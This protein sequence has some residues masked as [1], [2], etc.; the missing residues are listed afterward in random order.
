MNPAAGVSRG[1]LVREGSMKKVCL[2]ATVLFLFV[3]CSFAVT[4][5]EYGYAGSW[6]P[7]SFLVGAGNDR[8]SSG[9]SFDYDDQL[10][11]SEYF[12]LQAPAWRIDVDMLGITNRGWQEGWST[13]DPLA[14]GSGTR[15]SG[16]YD[17]T[18]VRVRL[19]IDVV[20]SQWFFLRMEPTVGVS[21]IGRQNYAF[22]Q[23]SLHRALGMQTVDLEYE[24]NSNKAYALFGGVVSLGGI[25]SLSWRTNLVV[26]LR[27]A[28]SNEIGFS[29][30]QKADAFVALRDAAYNDLLYVSF[31]YTWTQTKS[32]WTTA[33]LYDDYLRGFSLA[34]NVNAGFIRL[35][36]SCCLDTRRGYGTIGVDVL[37]FFSPTYWRRSDFYVSLGKTSMM[38]V[39]FFDCCLEKPFENSKFSLVIRSRYVSGSPAYSEDPAS[40]RDSFQY[41]RFERNYDGILVGVKYKFMGNVQE[42]FAAPYFQLC[43]GA[44]GWEALNLVNMNETLVMDGVEVRN[45]THS[46]STGR[47][48]SFAMDAELGMTLFPEGAVSSVRTSLQVILNAGLAFIHNPSEVASHLSS[49]TPDGSKVSM[50]MPRFGFSLLFGYD[51]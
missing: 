29:Y 24:T 22:L 13:V 30:R 39:A 12:S 2:A 21:M 40:G 34:Y 9:L 25:V 11:F 17:S 35:G 18:Q 28:S 14:K 49:Y 4:I 47:L 36:Y 32:K 37:S 38:D 20:R 3:F 10:S 26:G 5:G 15:V 8:W 19:P 1:G 50:F 27:G 16:R 44:M 42:S 33:M 41:G 31:G 6:I 45:Y 51:V 43:A 46:H 7:Q 23:N 48:Y